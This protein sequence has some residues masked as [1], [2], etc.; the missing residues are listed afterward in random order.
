VRPEKSVNHE[1]E[2]DDE[3]RIIGLIRRPQA[4]MPTEEPCRKGGVSNAT[5]YTR[6][7]SCGGMDMPRSRRLRELESE[8]A[9]LKRWLAGALR[10]DFSN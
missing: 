6:R 2:R 8:N 10:P 4:V 9:K 7:A 5:V 3:E 1:H